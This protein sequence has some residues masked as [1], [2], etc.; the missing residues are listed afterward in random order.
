VGEAASIKFAGD[1]RE[2]KAQIGVVVCKLLQISPSRSVTDVRYDNTLLLFQ[3]TVQHTIEVRFMTVE[4]TPENSTVLDVR[5]SIRM[6][7]KTENGVSWTQISS[8]C[9]VGVLCV[10]LRVDSR[11]IYFRTTTDVDDVFHA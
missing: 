2:S 11:E 7:I 10:N 1:V 3:H 9:G 5:A 4:Y 6:L 8:K